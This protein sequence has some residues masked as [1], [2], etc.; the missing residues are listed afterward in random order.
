MKKKLSLRV[1]AVLAINLFFG[2]IQLA[3]AQTNLTAFGSYGV[4]DI[5][6]SGLGILDLL[7]PYIKPI[8]QYTAGIQFGKEIGNHWD[9]V[10]GA[11]YSSRGFTA[12]DKFNIGVFGLDLPVDARIDTRLEYIE[13][14][15]MLKYSI[16]DGNITPYIKAGATAGYAVSG[17][18][19]P[20]VDAIITWKLPAINVN[21]ENDMYNRFDIAGIVGAGL[22][23]PIN[24][25]GALQFDVN[26][27]HSLNDMFHDKITDIRI[28]SYG[29]SGG[30]GYTMR[31]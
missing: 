6:V 28:K 9:I 23:V 3:S 16:G 1:K 22:N 19:Q 5:Q 2:F 29:F 30:I 7:D 11:Q 13:V 21:L 14:P 26:Y 12:R 31:F 4:S 25:T 27:R 10:T 15:L 17:K 18:Y 8:P 20:K 24:E